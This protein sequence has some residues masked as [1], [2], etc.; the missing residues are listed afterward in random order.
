LTVSEFND[1]LEQFIDLKPHA[2][3]EG[4]YIGLAVIWFSLLRMCPK[5]LIHLKCKS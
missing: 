3:S 2:A 5:D 1:F 4:L